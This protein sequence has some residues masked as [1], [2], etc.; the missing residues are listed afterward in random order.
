MSA[1]IVRTAIVLFSFAQ[2][3]FAQIDNTE[4]VWSSVVIT[5]YGDRTPLIAPTIDALTS[6]GAQQLY[7]VG[8]LFRE[9]YVAPPGNGASGT[10]AI[11]GISTYEIDSSQ[12][13][14]M[15]PADDFIIDSAQAFMQGLYPPLSVSS[16]TTTTP[17]SRLTN[18]SDIESPLGGYQYSQIYTTSRSDPNSIWLAGELNCPAYGR[19]AA[20]YLRSS[21]FLNLQSATQDFY[22]G[23]KSTIFDGELPNSAVSYQNAYYL[24]DYLNYG[25]TH[26]QTVKDSLSEADLF[27][28]RTLAD[29][30]EYAVNGNLSASGNTQGDQIRTIAGQTVAAEILGLLFTNVETSGRRSKLNL[31]FTS[32]EPMISFAA[33]AGLPPFYSNFY[34]LPDYGSSMVFEMFSTNANDSGGYPDPSDLRVRFLFRNGTDP[35]SNLNAYPLFGR[36]DGS[37]TMS[38]DDFATDIGRIMLASIGD[39]CTICGSMSVFCPAYTNSTF[40]NDSGSESDASTTTRHSGVQPVIAGVIGAIVALVVA[41]LLFAL[42]MLIGGV[43]L[44]RSK[45]KRRSELGG[46][47]GAEKLASDQDLTV[48]KGGAGATVVGKGHERIGSWELGESSKAKGVNFG[49]LHSP[50]P[51]R[52]PSYDGDDGSIHHNMEPTKV[53]E[54]V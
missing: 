31:L 21:E 8:S 27:Q 1:L 35:T 45:A 13:F 30:W 19:S 49:S 20:Q 22:S 14:A 44:S 15:A 39:W 34:G 52:R 23:F 26:N 25:Y 3:A 7:S 54:R 2:F 12:I 16:Q 24:F 38:L 5:R 6:L 40:I 53:A 42:A 48:I 28:A 9:R 10:S 29:Q 43:R 51:M 17:A 37:I 4:T 18:G 41:G 46:F 47:K 36:G 50:E 33:L 11:V 32:F